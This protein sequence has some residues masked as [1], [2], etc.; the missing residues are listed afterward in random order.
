M[1]AQWTA[2]GLDVKGA[3]FIVMWFKS[4]MLI[5]SEVPKA[6]YNIVFN[7]DNTKN[8]FLLTENGRLV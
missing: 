1:V 3:I 5:V 8:V 4:A 2:T 7:N 6:I